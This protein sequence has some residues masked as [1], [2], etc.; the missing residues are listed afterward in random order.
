MLV[1]NITGLLAYG[2]E[3]EARHQLSAAAAHYRKIVAYLPDSGY[4]HARLGAVLLKMGQKVEARRHLRAAVGY[5][6]ADPEIT[7]SLRA[8]GEGAPK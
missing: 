3:F 6:I 8:I 4:A 2:F 1:L 5:G 7:A